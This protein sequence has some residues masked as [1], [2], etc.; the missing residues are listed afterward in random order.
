MGNAHG[1]WFAERSTRGQLCT[2]RRG[3]PLATKCFLMHGLGS[4]CLHDA[5]ALNLQ[6]LVAVQAVGSTVSNPSLTGAGCPTLAR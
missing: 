4:C 1:G 6:A 5:A 2:C 3:T